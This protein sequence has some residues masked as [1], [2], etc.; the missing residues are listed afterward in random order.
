MISGECV[1]S[2]FV[3]LRI[4]TRDLLV[5]LAA[6]RIGV[7]FPTFGV[8]M[9]V[10]GDPYALQIIAFERQLFNSLR[11]KEKLGWR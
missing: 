8:N 10:M 2:F 6:V 5:V 11:R 3:D 1:V 4:V 7:Q 9:N